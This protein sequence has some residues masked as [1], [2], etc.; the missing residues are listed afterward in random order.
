M[1]IEII[2]TGEEVLSGQITDTNSSWVCQLLEEHGLQV[3]R[4]STVGDRREDLLAVFQERSQ[5]AEVIIVNGGLGPTVDDLSA[6]IAAQALGESLVRR[7]EWVERLEEMFEKSG[8]KLN[9]ENL[10]QAMLPPSAEIIDNPVGTA[11]GFMIQLNDALLYFTPGVPY[12]FKRMMTHEIIPDIKKRFHIETVCRLRRLHCF[13]IA[14]SRLDGL[15]RDISLPDTVKLGFRAHLPTIEIKIMGLSKS[16]ET[17]TVEMDRVAD[18]IRERVADRMIYE[19]DGS[20]Q[21]EIQDAMIARNHTLALAESCTGGMIAEQLVHVAGSSAYFERGFV[22][23]SNEAKIES[24][25]V[26]P[27]LIERHGAVSAE[28]A[29]AMARGAQKTAGV[30]HALSVTGVAGPEGG[31]EEKPVGTVAFGLATPDKVHVQ[32]LRA[33]N[34][35]RTRIRTISAAVA[36]DMLRRDLQGLDPFGHYDLTRTVSTKTV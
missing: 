23:Y 13:G 26:P 6:E 25:G 31:S 12:E 14:E 32:M 18:A 10:K 34:W 1:K 8:R 28:V 22:T 2:S 16:E 20:L 29:E 7:R 36:L 35:G 11:C 19:G 33:P 24:I 3:S 17:L 4:R 27:E 21:Q 15:L 5:K 9:P 30:S